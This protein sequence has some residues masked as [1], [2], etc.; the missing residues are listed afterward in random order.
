MN[1]GYAGFNHHKLNWE[2]SVP[3][4]GN[5]HMPR[6]ANIIINDLSKT[7]FKHPIKS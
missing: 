2:I 4:A 3:I 7:N 5:M 6:N 1:A